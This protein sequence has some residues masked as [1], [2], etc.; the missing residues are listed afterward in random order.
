M[1][2]WFAASAKISWNN[3]TKVTADSHRQLLLFLADR[4]RMLDIENRVKC[5]I[6]ARLFWHGK[7]IEPSVD[8][9]ISHSRGNFGAL[10][11]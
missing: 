9:R 8:A 6:V 11:A 1:L 3:R 5:E 4:R 10:G 2:N 7:P